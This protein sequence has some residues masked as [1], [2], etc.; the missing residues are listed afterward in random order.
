MKHKQASVSIA[1]LLTILLENFDFQKSE[2]F[3]IASMPF[4]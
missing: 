3:G 1:A 4:Y 2:I